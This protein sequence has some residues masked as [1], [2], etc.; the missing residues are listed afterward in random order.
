MELF[1]VLNHLVP[2]PICIPFFNHPNR[3]SILTLHFLI[4]LLRLVLLP[5]YHCHSGY[6]LVVFSPPKDGPDC[7]RS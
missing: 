4:S 2:A 6:S 3:I 5:S 1:T 7:T